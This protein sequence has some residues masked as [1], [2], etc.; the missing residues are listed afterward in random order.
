LLLAAPGDSYRL[1]YGSETAKVPSYDTAAMSESLGKGY[2]PIPASLS[3]QFANAGASEPAG[4]AVRGLL[5]NPLALGALIVVL[6]AVL[7]WG[8]YRAGRR[9]EHLPRDSGGAAP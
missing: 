8:L 3:E 5:N 4:A 6:V 7:A 1:F 2:R 9:I